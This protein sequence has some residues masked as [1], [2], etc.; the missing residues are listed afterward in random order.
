MAV[1]LVLHEQDKHGRVK[2][3]VPWRLR[4]EVVIGSLKKKT[5]YMQGQDQDAVVSA[6]EIMKNRMSQDEANTEQNSFVDK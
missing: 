5:E 3:Q 1:A 4:F 2:H 6:L